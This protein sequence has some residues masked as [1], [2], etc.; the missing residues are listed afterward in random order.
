MDEGSSTSRKGG[1]RISFSTSPATVVVTEASN[2]EFSPE[3]RAKAEDAYADAAMNGDVMLSDVSAILETMGYLSG[4][5]YD[6]MRRQKVVPKD[7]EVVSQ[8]EFVLL[9]AGIEE[10]VQEV[11][12]RPGGTKALANGLTESLQEKLKK[13]FTSIDKDGSGSVTLDEAINFWGKNFAKVNATA[14]FKE[15]DSDADGMRR[16]AR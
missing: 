2:T 7:Q 9:S 3:L 8:S 16:R 5:C 11:G 14:M 6:F 13:F 4:T 15:V 1:R 12:Q 10:F